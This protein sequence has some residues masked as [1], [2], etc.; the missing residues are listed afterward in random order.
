LG[1]KDAFVF[2][3][4][5]GRYKWNLKGRYDQL[6]QILA[7]SR[8]PVETVIL[9]PYVEHAYIIIFK[10]GAWRALLPLAQLDQLKEM[11]EEQNKHDVQMAARRRD[12]IKQNWELQQNIIKGVQNIINMWR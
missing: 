11:I 5:R 7:N 12:T 4:G 2:V 6:G 1:V 10:N 3:D 9:N 8:L